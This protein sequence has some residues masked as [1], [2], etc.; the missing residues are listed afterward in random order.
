L[1]FMN[2]QAPLKPSSP[3]AWRAECAAII[4][5]FN[6]ERNIGPLIGRVLRHVQTV[7]VID[8]GSTDR[9]A[10][11][12][13]QAGAQVIKHQRNLGKGAALQTG[14]QHAR[15]LGFHWAI[16][17]DGDG[18]H[19]PE[20]IP[21]FFETAAR[22]SAAMVVG[23]RMSNPREMPWVRRGVNRWM[24]HRISRAA[25][26]PL[27]D[28]QCGFRLLDLAVLASIPIT[29]RHFEIESEVLLAFSQTGHRIEFVPI[30]V[31][32]KAE[33]SKIHPVRD[34]LRWF[35]WWR[36]RQRQFPG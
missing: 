10:E 1:D 24:S 6:E 28:S 23:N 15:E 33:R 36:H 13:Q 25:G 21:A 19:A 26:T 27:P 31:I 32:Y 22:C 8:D 18:Q 29:T 11:L 9:T 34:T 2:S 30:Q 3:T 7:L 35:R 4:P 17:I 16:T 14:W 5:C 12:A 20:D